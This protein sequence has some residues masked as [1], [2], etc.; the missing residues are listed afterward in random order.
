M[1]RKPKKSTTTSHETESLHAAYD[2]PEN[3]TVLTVFPAR[4]DRRETRWL[5]IDVAH[6]VALA[7]VR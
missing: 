3:P 1:R 2:D 6:A 5:S 4:T 7:D